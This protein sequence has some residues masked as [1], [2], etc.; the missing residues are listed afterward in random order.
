[1]KTTAKCGH[2]ADSGSGAIPTGEAGPKT[3]LTEKTLI[4][5][6][7]RARACDLEVFLAN[8]RVQ[9]KVQEYPGLNGQPNAVRLVCFE[10]FQVEY[11]RLFGEPHGE[12]LF[13]KARNDLWRARVQEIEEQIAKLT[14]EKQQIERALTAIP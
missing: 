1:M 9:T 12:G 5:A 13:V 6:L 3:W 10:D 4:V 7:D 11:R 14:I 2:G 8:G